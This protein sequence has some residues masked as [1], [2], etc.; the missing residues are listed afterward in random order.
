MQANESHHEKGKEQVPRTQQEHIPRHALWQ[1]ILQ[2]R[3]DCNKIP[4]W[5][6]YPQQHEEPL[7]EKKT[8]GL[9]SVDDLDQENKD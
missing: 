8:V 7:Y 9:T 3:D 2:K 4:L 6:D 5:K 1:Q